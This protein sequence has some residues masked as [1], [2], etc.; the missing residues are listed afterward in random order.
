MANRR[1]EPSVNLYELWL[2]YPTQ[3]IKLLKDTIPGQ[4]TEFKLFKI[5]L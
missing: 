1:N 3:L 4:N 2:G 5:S